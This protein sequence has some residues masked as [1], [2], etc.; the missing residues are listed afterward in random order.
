MKNKS[1]IIAII[2]A[3]FISIA[4]MPVSTGAAYAETTDDIANDSEVMDENSIDNNADVD[5]DGQ[6]SKNVKT[7]SSEDIVYENLDDTY[8]CYANANGEMTKEKHSW[9]RG[10]SCDYVDYEHHQI[11]YTCDKCGATQTRDEDHDYIEHEGEWTDGYEEYDDVYYETWSTCKCGAVKGCGSGAGHEWEALYD[12][13]FDKKYDSTYHCLVTERCTYCGA[14]KGFLV[15]HDDYEPCYYKYAKIDSEYHNV[16]KMCH[17]CGLVSTKKARHSKAKTKVVKKATLKSKGKVQDVC[18][19]GAVI[20]T[21]KVSWKYNTKYS[22]S[23][24]VTWNTNVYRNSKHV[25]VTLKNP[26]KGSTVIVQIG[27]KKYKKKVGK[28]KKVKIK[29]NKPKKYGQK[30]YIDVKY[31]GKWIGEARYYD[32]V[33]YAITTGANQM[34][35]PAGP[36]V[37]RTGITMTVHILGLRMVK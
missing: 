28:G 23:Y 36:V 21:K 18:I 32:V 33:Y 10:S 11:T 35:P 9:R 7:M 26:V 25:T 12:N 8:H 6:E 31:K 14:L 13:M 15:R 2:T 37:G 29:I 4:F 19:C 16:K 24:N 30:I 27:K 22:V 1:R 17:D 20:K 3:F 34:I 5:G